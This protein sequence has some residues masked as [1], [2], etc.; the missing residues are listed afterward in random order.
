MCASAQ[1]QSDICGR[2]AFSGSSTCKRNNYAIALGAIGAVSSGVMIFLS[3]RGNLGIMPE[4]LVSGLMF[5]M[6]A[7]GVA[8]ITFGSGP[9]IEIGNIYFATWIGFAVAFSLAASCFHELMAARMGEMDAG[10]EPAASTQPEV[11]VEEDTETPATTEAVEV[12][13]K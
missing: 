2:D 6:Y 8:Y 3:G 1:L 10:E 12:K 9:G 13:T 4:T 7:F 5:I 11:A